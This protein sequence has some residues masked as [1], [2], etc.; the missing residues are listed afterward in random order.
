MNYQEAREYLDTANTKGSVYGLESIKT[1]LEKLNNPQDKLKFVHISGTNG[2]G[3][4]LAFISTVL[5]VAGYKVGRYVSPTV[6]CYEERIQVN[7]EYI[8]NDA[9]AR[10]TT[11]V[12]KAVDEITVERGFT[13][14]AFEI[15]TAIALL[16][17]VET[18]CDI[19][20]LETGLGGSM[21]A[22]NIIT[23]TV[24]SVIASISMDHMNILG[25]TLEEIASAK[26]G[27]IKPNVPVVSAIQKPEA[28]AVIEKTAKE[29]NS[30][31]TVVNRD[32]VYDVSRENFIQKF[33]YNGKYN[34]YKNIT[35]QLCGSYQIDNAILAIEAL[36]CLSRN[37]FTIPKECIYKGIAD[38][39]WVGRFTKVSDE[40]L[41]FIDGAHNEA[42]ANKLS[43]TLEIYFTNK[44]ITYIMGVLEDKEYDKI[45]DIML[46]HANTVLTITPNNPRALSAEALAEK[47]NAK[48]VTSKSFASVR[49][50][51]IDAIEC[52]GKDSVVLVFGSLYYLGEVLQAMKEFSR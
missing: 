27:I 13:P 50:A 29:M 6:I 1:L 33:S 45:L 12:K 26:A 19:V 3:S 28:M 49:D 43:E 42:A 16:Y 8:T 23:T 20:T 10:L 37:G 48:G 31:L 7:E 40:P 5:K 24:V 14:T 46:P 51:L 34:V 2:K 4:T 22:T 25:N 11:I 38:A 32:G 9:L 35:T 47:I 41:I 30:E 17:F 21:D 44:K 18:Q 39:V 36:A 15:E 52:A